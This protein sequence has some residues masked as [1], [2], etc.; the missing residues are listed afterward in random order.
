M[1][2]LAMALIA[3]SFLVFTWFMV[4]THGTEDGNSFI[5]ILVGLFVTLGSISFIGDEK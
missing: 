5:I 2:Y 1:R 3:I 4:T